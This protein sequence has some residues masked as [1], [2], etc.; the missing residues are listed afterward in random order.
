MSDNPI[1]KRVYA[2]AGDR[3]ETRNVYAAWA[4][5]YDTDTL[6]GMGYVAPKLAA[7]A[8]A[9][10]VDDTARV[11]DAGCGTGLVGEELSRHGLGAVDGID[12][13]PGMLEVA[14]EKNV[15]RNLD[16]ADLTEAL[17]IADDSYDAAISVG[18]F[19]S[20]HVG[21]EAIADLARVVKKDAPL[22]ITVHENVWEAQAYPDALTR[23]EE[24]GHLR[25]NDLIDAPYHER[26][27]YR[28]RLCLLSAV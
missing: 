13:S 19:T 21:P 12:L 14:A 17:K 8:L 26:E 11:L 16:V 24:E 6:R 15:Y 25:I 27:G 3:D 7:A 4:K 20:G 22:V 1:L 28:C 23:F 10:L 5:D 9:D 2:L 18:V